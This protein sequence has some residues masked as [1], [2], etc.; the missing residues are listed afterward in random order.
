RRAPRLHARER[1]RG[2]RRSGRRGAH[3]RRRRGRGGVMGGVTR[4]SIALALALTALVAR[5]AR[6]EPAAASS[7]PDPD[8]YRALRFRSG[9]ALTG[10]GVLSAVMG[11]GFGVRTLVD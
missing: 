5:P 3:G 8:E 9:I 7:E 6:A 10:A 11:G 2:R 1:G 4:A